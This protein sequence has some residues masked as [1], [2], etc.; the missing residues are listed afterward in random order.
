MRGNHSLHSTSPTIE[1][2]V[3]EGG[4]PGRGRPTHVR[5]NPF[6]GD[7]LVYRKFVA[8]DIAQPFDRPDVEAFRDY[9]ARATQQVIPYTLEVAEV[10]LFEQERI[11]TNKYVGYDVFECSWPQFS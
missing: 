2:T 9:I 3:R 1:D 6:S 7:G 5:T 10:N 4:V 11:D 8:I